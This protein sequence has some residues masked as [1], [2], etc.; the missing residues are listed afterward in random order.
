MEWFKPVT[1]FF[2]AV[3]LL[4]VSG[5]LTPVDVL[6]GFANEQLAVI[7][8]LLVFSEII[9]TTSVIDYL[10]DRIFHG[11][12]GTRGFM[13]RMMAWVAAGS[14]IF[15]N[16]P[17]VA[18]MMPYVY[19][20]SRRNHVSPS[21][22]MIPL[23]YAAI[24]GG[25]VTLVGTSTNLIVDG[26]AV[27]AGLPAM[28]IFDFAWVGLPML[29]VGMAY[30][31]LFGKKLLPNREEVIE[32]FVK[33]SR[34]FFV[35]AQV[36]A[37]SP[38]V[39]KM[40]Q[41]A[42]LRHLKGLY[43]VEIIRGHNHITVVSPDELLEEEDILIFTGNTESLAELKNPE[44]G[45]SLPKTTQFPEEDEPDIV[46]IVISQN[47][48]L[49]DLKIQDTDFRGNWDAA[50]LAVHRNRER[51]SG[52]IGNI[53]LR[54][55]DVLLL[56]AGNDFH[57]RIAGVQAFYIISQEEKPQEADVNKVLIMVAGIIGAIVLS[58]TGLLPLFTG[59]L[60][61][62]GIVLL[63]D[64]VPLVVVR[65]GM[66]YSLLFILALGLAIGKGM[67]NSGAADLVAGWVLAIA[68]PLGP[69]ALLAVIFVIG[70]LMAAYI[71]NKAA[72]AILFPIALSIAQTMELNHTP[73]VLITAF[74]CA[75]SFITPIGYQTNLMVMGPGGYSFRDFFKVGLPLTLLYMVGCVLILSYVYDLV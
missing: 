16:T 70:N 59:L 13:A 44:L 28:G 51:L 35:E 58:A 25:C 45:L 37:G 14:S 38:L 40:I 29:F 47:S 24:L 6:H 33:T 20:W 74:S 11:A 27:E 64:V 62:L 60:I 9:R 73:F 52:K 54:P 36:K 15:N 53:E 41:E 34:E 49:A 57:T 66:D 26:M 48:R 56:L 68:Q 39:G 18:M 7:I 71:T 69:V 63:M 43:L 23:S 32:E 22:L 12:G 10:F 65:K 42:E 46:E 55:G 67:I 30:L 1:T 61:L 17:L 72:V 5:I 31:L 4:T 19:N 21:K 50:V 3:I 75:A 2:V 8:L